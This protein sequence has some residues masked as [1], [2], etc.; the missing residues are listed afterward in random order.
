MA[1]RPV[2]LLAL[3]LG[4]LSLVDRQ[5]TGLAADL[6]PGMLL[7]YE[8]EGARQPPWSVDSVSLGG[9]LRD[10][11][12]CVVVHL[13]RRPDQAPEQSRLCLANDTLY[14]WDDGVAGWTVS[15]PVGTRM[16]WTSRAANGDIVRYETEEAGQETISGRTIPVIHTTVTT[17]DSTGRAK[18]RLR[19][20]YA[21]SLITATG[22][23]FE[24][25]DSTR[26]GHWL[27]QRRFELREIR[28]AGH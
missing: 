11:S 9:A 14:R 4:A 2:A 21:V 8:S 28:A 13:R 20:R 10:R 18:R 3:L 25:A 17:A 26:T 5:R 16:S 22:G 27:V 19:E 15:R 1:V 23:A 24:T 6:E 7:F 12:E